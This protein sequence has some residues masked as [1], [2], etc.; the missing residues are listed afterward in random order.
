MS[1]S[2]AGD[3]GILLGG[4]DVRAL[5]ER[6]DLRPTKRLG[7]NFVT[8]PNTVRRIAR[9]ARLTDDGMHLNDEGARVVAAAIA[10]EL[11]A[12]PPALAAP[13]MLRIR[14]EVA[15]KNR[16]WFDTWRPANWSF[17]YGDRVSQRFAQ[18]S[19][20]EP[21]LKQAFE[22]HKPMIAEAEARIHAL[23]LG[24]EAAPA[25]PVAPLPP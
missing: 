5:A 20:N 2:A 17:V 12:R 3:T 24:R 23:A 25:V 4:R 10:A 13:A 8:D 15:A 19:G 22:Q 1:D 14:D 6:L 11:G 16:L 7:Q 9:A 21:S 18:G